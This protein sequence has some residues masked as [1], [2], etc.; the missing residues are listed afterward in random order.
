MYH[1]L[2]DGQVNGL[3]FLSLAVAF[4]GVSRGCDLPAGA[5]IAVAA[6]LKLTPVALLVYLAWR[7]RWRDAAG[8]AE[9]A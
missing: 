8:S 6:A 5:G 2:I 7:R 1:T 9:R 3:V 4:L